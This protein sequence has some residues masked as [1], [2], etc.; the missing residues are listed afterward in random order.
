MDI[1]QNSKAQKNVDPSQC[2]WKAHLPPASSSF[3]QP[4]PT[5]MWNEGQQQFTVD[6]T[7]VSKA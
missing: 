1:L 7:L 3:N 6:Q 4:P 5:R 2:K